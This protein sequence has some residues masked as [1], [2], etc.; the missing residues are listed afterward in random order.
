[1]LATRTRGRTNACLLERIC[2]FQV[3]KLCIRFVFALPE[4]TNT[5]ISFHTVHISLISHRLFNVLFSFGH[6]YNLARYHVHY[7]M[8]ERPIFVYGTL[9][10]GEPNN[11]LLNDKTKGFAKFLGKAKLTDKYPL[12]VATNANVPLLLPKKGLGKVST[13]CITNF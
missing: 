5:N 10:K 4:I 2:M 11:Y 8:E 6:L 3:H 13:M 9:K 7:K 12:V 1:M